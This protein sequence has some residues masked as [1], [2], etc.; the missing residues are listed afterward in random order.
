MRSAMSGRLQLGSGAARPVTLHAGKFILERANETLL[1]GLFPTLIHIAA[2]DRSLGPVRTLLEMNERE[3]RHPGAASEFVIVRL[4]EL[5]LIEIL[6]TVPPPTG[7]KLTGLLGGLED[8]VV[9]KALVAMHREVARDWTVNSLA[10]LCGVS[11]SAFAARFRSI[12]GI[13][14][15]DYLLQWRMA[16]A[17]DALS[18]GTKSVGEIAFSIGFQ[19]SSAFT[20]AFTRAVGHSPTKFALLMADSAHGGQKKIDDQDQS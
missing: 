16:L 13:A 14:P 15:I 6:R 1:A 7:D 20:T 5:V 4:V 9:A 19:S 8:G 18:L 2:G 11:R 12:V 3:A 17:K 10:K